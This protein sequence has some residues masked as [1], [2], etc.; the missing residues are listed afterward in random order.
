MLGRVS[1][2]SRRKSAVKDEGLFLVDSSPAEKNEHLFLL[3]SFSGGRGVRRGKEM[4]TTHTYMQSEP[5]LERWSLRPRTPQFNL[6]LKYSPALRYKYNCFYR[7][8]F[9][10]SIPAVISQFFSPAN[11]FLFG[12]NVDASIKT[13]GNSDN[14]YTLHVYR[15]ATLKNPWCQPRG[16]PVAINRYPDKLFLMWIQW[17]LILFLTTFCIFLGSALD[18]ITWMGI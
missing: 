9:I 5:N 7:S 8:R 3:G 16:V 18:R 14:F 17:K 4:P 2:N 11:L 12:K 15:N 10:G 13:G 6:I 1:C